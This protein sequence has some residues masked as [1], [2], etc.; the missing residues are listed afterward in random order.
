MKLKKGPRKG[1]PSLIIINQFGSPCAWLES[2]QKINLKIFSNYNLCMRE[3][4]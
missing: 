4:F 2:A 3:V 1:A